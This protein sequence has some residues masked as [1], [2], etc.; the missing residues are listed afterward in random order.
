M[1]SWRW[2]AN[3]AH[4]KLGHVARFAWVRKRDADWFEFHFRS[5]TDPAQ[6][7]ANAHFTIMLWKEAGKRSARSSRPSERCCTACSS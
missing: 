2:L 5:G 4:D 1:Q 3:T 6:S 7:G